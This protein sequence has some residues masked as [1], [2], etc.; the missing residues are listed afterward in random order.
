MRK[1]AQVKKQGADAKWVVVHETTSDGV[2]LFPFATDEDGS[3]IGDWWFE[4]MAEADAS[5][6]AEYDIRPSDWIQIPDPPSGCQQD[7]ICPV[8]V[9]GREA[10]SPE[11]GTLERL[12]DGEWIRIDPRDRR[13]TVV[14]AI[15]Q[16]NET[17]GPSG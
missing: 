15:Q 9:P 1:V 4:T 17:E 7:W 13:P 12:V 6:A 2:Y 3:S 10:G 14:W 16:A 8:R 11:W 5:C